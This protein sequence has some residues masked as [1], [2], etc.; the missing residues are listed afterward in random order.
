MLNTYSP[1]HSHIIEFNRSAQ[2]LHLESTLEDLSL[3]EIQVDINQ[4][5]VI[6]TQLFES[7]STIPGVIL[8]DGKKFIGMISQRR[9]FE[10]M[11]RPYARELFLGRSLH[12]FYNFAQTDLLLLSGDTPVVEAAQQ[13]IRR[14]PHLLYEP[15][16]VKLSSDEY[17]LL[18]VQ[19]L[20]IAQS[21]IHQLATELLRQKTQA[22]LIQTEKLATLGQMLA[23]VSHE[24]R[25]PVACILGNLQCLSHYYQDLMGLAETYEQEFPQPSQAI[26]D[27]K[28][29]IDFEFTQQDLPEV[30]DSIKISSER[31]THLVNSL[32]GFSRIDS[33]KPEKVEINYCLENTLLILKNRFKPGTNLI[34][35]YGKIPPIYGYPNQLSQVFLNI[36]SNAIDALEDISQDHPHLAKIT[37]KTEVRECSEIEKQTLKIP[38]HSPMD[39]LLHYPEYFDHSSSPNSNCDCQTQPSNHLPCCI[40]IR[41]SD[42]GPGIPASILDRIFETFFTTKSP[43]KGT[44]LGLSISHQIITEKHRGKLNVTSQVG[45]GTEFEILLPIL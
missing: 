27:Y 25:N 2:N 19:Q 1:D 26:K 23:G 15:I 30:L 24:I 12:I 35:K 38:S 44:G 42:N 16:V 4:R 5:G 33:Y 39:A 34:K 10:R 29:E 31:L 20:L 37:I 21:C 3:F 7:D 40:S 43:E 17:R 45:R 6:V 8:M 18:E 32:R 22:Q 28:N 9:F 11:S 36:I 14:S 13:A 41:I